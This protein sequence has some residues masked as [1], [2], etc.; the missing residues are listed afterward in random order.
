[1]YKRTNKSYIMTRDIQCD[2]NNDMLLSLRSVYKNPPYEEHL[3]NKFKFVAIHI[4]M[5]YRRRLLHKVMCVLSNK[6]LEESTIVIGKI[7]SFNKSG[8]HGLIHSNNEDYMFCKNDICHKWFR[9]FFVKDNYIIGWKKN[10]AVYD[11]S[12]I[13]NER[14]LKLGNTQVC[15]TGTDNGRVRIKL[16]G[17]KCTLP[18]YNSFVY[19]NE[20]VKV[21]LAYKAHDLYAIRCHYY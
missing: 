13:F 1:M 19:N 6:E 7:K 11:I 17:K 21:K 16:F 4:F 10:N 2:A 20:K 14:Y 8:N 9:Y 12:P 3:M 15:G 5:K 18:L